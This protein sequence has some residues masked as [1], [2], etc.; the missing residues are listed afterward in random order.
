MNEPPGATV[1]PAAG[2]P[3]VAKGATVPVV[4]LTVAGLVL[5]LVTWTLVV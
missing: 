2:S 5:V 3:V 1:V 4:P